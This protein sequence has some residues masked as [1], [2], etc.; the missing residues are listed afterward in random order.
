M[1]VDIVD[2]A[3]EWLAAARAARR[4]GGVV[5][6][7]LWLALAGALAH[8]ADP[9]R[10]LGVDSTV[11][12]LLD[13]PAA[14]AV[15]E[16]HIP[17]FVNSPGVEQA[18]D[19]GLRA[20]QVYAPTILTD[21]AL[22][23]IADDLARTPGAVAHG[24]PPPRVPPP[25]D[26]GFAFRLR[27]IPLWEGPAP[28]ARGDAPQ[29][30]PTL[31]LI[32]TDG[33]VANGAAIIVAPGGGYQALATG[34][35]GRQVADWFAAHGVAAF[36]LSYRLVTFGYRHPVALLDAQR[37]VRW[38]RAHAAEYGIDP[39][40]IGMI[41]FSAG[42]HLTAMVSTQFDDGD[43]AAADPVERV[44]SRPD[45]AILGYPVIAWPEARWNELE[46]VDEHTSA[47]GLR[48]LQ[49]AGNVDEHTPP[50]FIFHTTDDEV[51]APA[52]A[53]AY[54]EALVAAKVPAELHVFGH[55]RH[56]LGLAMHDRTLGAWPGLLDAWLGQRG[57]LGVSAQR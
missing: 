52:N 5:L 33:A 12:E 25:A 37:A 50:T 34:H 10:R 21:T 2:G 15:L 28:H 51:V 20:L 14:R 49:P 4:H 53:I 44:S 42:G 48:Q 41:G 40:R 26:P 7:A 3:R 36:V 9:V 17:V 6:C 55:G 46:L 29:D 31:T 38:V 11:G 56:G 47:Q 18:R 13:N 1:I 57:L 24:A 8:A 54:Y 45:F 23:Q 39:S 30:T 35:E 16:R 27:T 32:G 22:L 19:L 43:A